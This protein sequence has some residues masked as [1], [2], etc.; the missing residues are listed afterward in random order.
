[1]LKIEIQNLKGRY[2]I[3]LDRDDYTAYPDEKEILMQAGLSSKVVSYQEETL[4]SG[5]KLTTFHLQ[6][7][8]DLIRRQLLRRRFQFI[9]PV[10][11]FAFA[12][13][14]QVIRSKRS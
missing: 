5:K 6:I 7:N 1:M 9:I 8:D 3:S 13:L 11:F 14:W 2:F 12:T 10:L 4:N